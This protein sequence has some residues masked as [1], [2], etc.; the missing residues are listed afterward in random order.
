MPLFS[1]EE[2]LSICVVFFGIYVLGSNLNYSNIRSFIYSPPSTDD[3]ILDKIDHLSFIK[4][5]EM[6][7]K[8]TQTEDTAQDLGFIETT[9]PF[10]PEKDYKKLLEKLRS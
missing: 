6:V 4:D 3:V 1:V 7:D 8:S 2:S 5:K 9:G 10:E